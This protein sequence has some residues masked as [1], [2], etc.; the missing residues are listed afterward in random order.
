MNCSA[1]ST[2]N[3]NPGQL[4]MLS[5]STSPQKRLED[6]QI[7]LKLKHNLELQEIVQRELNNVNS[8]LKQHQVLHQTLRDKKARELNASQQ[9]MDYNEMLRQQV[10]EKDQRD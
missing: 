3:L 6:N 7:S 5:V 10:L 4:N 9:Q 8:F 1:R 2:K